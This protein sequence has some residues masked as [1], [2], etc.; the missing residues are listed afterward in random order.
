MAI[1]TYICMFVCVSVKN[2]C[3]ESEAYIQKHYFFTT[4]SGSSMLKKKNQI[5][6]IHQ[7]FSEYPHFHSANVTFTKY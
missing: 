3:I 5:S 7:K 1:Y 2:D 4:S 6:V